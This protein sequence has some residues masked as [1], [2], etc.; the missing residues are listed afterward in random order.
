MWVGKRKKK[1]EDCSPD[2]TTTRRGARDNNL[3]EDKAASGGG[4]VDGA[5]G[6][7]VG[8]MATG[9]EARADGEQGRPRRQETR[10]GGDKRQGRVEE[11]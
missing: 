10:R 2:A 8:L 5:R 9:T 11:K 6:L 3:D 1:L 7:K 4:R